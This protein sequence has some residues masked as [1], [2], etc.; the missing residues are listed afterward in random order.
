M[1]RFLGPS[2]ICLCFAFEAAPLMFSF[3]RT[4]GLLGV[5]DHT[6]R[7]ASSL[8][9]LRDT[10]LGSS[11]ILGPRNHMIILEQADFDEHFFIKRKYSSPQ[12]PPPCL[13]SL[14]KPSPPIVPLPES[15][16]KDSN[17]L[18]RSQQPVHGVDGSMSSELP[19]ALPETPASH[20][21]FQ[22]ALTSSPSISPS[23]SPSP[24]IEAPGPHPQHQ[25]CPR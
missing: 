24:S 25:H 2:L 16:V 14:L 1:S 10:R 11:T 22:T 8:G 9:I 23:P 4:R 13:D 12:L 19:T 18:S 7:S 5:L 6:W 21:F 17:E 20:S 15:L 3:R